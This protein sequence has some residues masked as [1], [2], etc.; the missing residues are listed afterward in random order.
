MGENNCLQPDFKANQSN[1]VSR[2]NFLAGLGAL[3]FFGQLGSIT[4]AQAAFNFAPFSFVVISDSHLANGMPDTL[5]LLQE[6][7]LFLQ[8]AVKSINEQQVDFVIFAGDQVEGIGRDEA[9]WQLF[10]DIMSN[11]NCP[12]Y[13]VL[14]E[15]DVSGPP[16][17]D[18]MRTYGPDFKG[19]GVTSDKSYWSADPMPG[20]H[21]IGLD[22][23][24]ANS[25]TGDLSDVQ[26]SWLKKDLA[27]NKG[28]LTIVVSHHPLLAPPPY[29]GGPPFEE[30]TVSQGASAREILGGSQDVRLAISGHVPI[31]K[32][33]RE[34]NVWFVSCPPLDVYPC[35][36]K[37][38][39]VSMQGIT[40]ETLSIRY[41]ALVKKARKVMINSRLAFQFSDKNP[42]SFLRLAEG[43]ELDRTAFLPLAPGAVAQRL[44]KSK[45]KKKDKNDKTDKPDKNDKTEKTDDAANDGKDGKDDAA[46]EAKPAK[47]GKADRDEKSEKSAKKKKDKPDKRVKNDKPDKSDQPQTEKSEKKQQK[48]QNEKPSDFDS[49][50]IEL[51][52]PPRKAEPPVAP[53]APESPL[54]APHI[55][56]VP[57]LVPAPS[58][59]PAPDVSKF[60]PGP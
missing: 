34:R 10:I 9:F 46:S 53:V 57:N 6:S 52:K 18:R 49:A 3:T 56:P 24:R 21:L 22:T 39:H 15:T 23:A 44:I 7:Q 50:P 42:E 32:I 4:A 8:D 45:I 11:L 29:D 17:V 37:L 14:G 25:E 12:W 43:A 30:Y 33:Q 51:D 36:F 60:M 48:E 5:K 47:P 28:K 58:L 13:F 19:R 41:E 54:P 16:A 35:Q 59:V 27:A 40:V 55:V 38:F 20:T 26:L 1:E 31:N 2:R